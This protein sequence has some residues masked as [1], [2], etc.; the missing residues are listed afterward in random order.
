MATNNANLCVSLLAI[1]DT[2]M[3][4]LAGLFDTLSVSRDVANAHIPFDLEIVAS[5]AQ[6]QIGRTRMPLN[7]HRT[8][9]GIEK[10][11]IAI[12]PA[13]VM[14]GETWIP[15]RYPEE[16][17][18]LGSMHRRGAVI[19]SACSGALLLAETGLLDGKEATS[20]WTLERLSEV[21]SQRSCCNWNGS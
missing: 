12:I 6:L 1:P 11:D 9:D 10:T 7:A 2:F 20:H 18:W 5:K 14:D 8:I 21:I 4:C 13:S 3:S 17:R 15:G 16:V 19:C